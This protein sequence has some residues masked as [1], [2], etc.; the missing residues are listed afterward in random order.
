MT[1]QHI[2]LITGASRGI[3]FSTAEYLAK[4]GHLVIGLARHVPE[5][6]FPGEFFTVDL[7]DRH[8][9]TETMANLTKQYAFDGVLNNVAVINPQPLEEL[10]LDNFEGVIDLNLRVAI[11]TV[12]AV[13][14]SMKAKKWGRIVNVSS[15]A[16]LGV[17]NRTSYAIAKAG[18]LGMTRTWALE[19]V[20]SG[21][22]VN[23]V[24]PG[25]IETEKTQRICPPGSELRKQCISGVPMERFGQPSEVAATIGF[26]FSEEA[27]YMTGQTLFVDGGCSININ[28]CYKPR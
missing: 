12:Q 4:Q 9:T 8:G 24:A 17:Q 23:A 16:S 28:P 21:I 18:M 14:P 3:G 6:P 15:I 7:S 27:G 10:T 22:T 2:T 1:E 26:L 5:K 19:L 20:K 11:Q 25:P 13:V